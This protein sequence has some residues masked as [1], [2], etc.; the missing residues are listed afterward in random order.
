MLEVTRQR[1]FSIATAAYLA[2]IALT[3]LAMRLSPGGAFLDTRTQGYSFTNNFFNELGMTTANNGQA[4]TWS[5][6]LYTVVNFHTPDYP[7]TYAWVSLLFAGLMIA[8]VLILTYGP[9]IDA[10]QG[11]V[12]QVVSKKTI[13]YASIFN[14]WCSPGVRRRSIDLHLN[15]YQYLKEKEK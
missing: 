13:V 3:L 6:I 12:T 5:A 10:H 8:Y 4:H 15:G 2:F 11:Y 9:E 1:I 14:M 7:N